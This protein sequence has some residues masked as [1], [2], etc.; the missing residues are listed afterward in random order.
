MGASFL[1]T[2]KV[3]STDRNHLTRIPRPASASNI[4]KG[5]LLGSP[6][7]RLKGKLDEENFGHF[8]TQEQSRTSFPLSIQGVVAGWYPKELEKTSLMS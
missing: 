1:H 7:Q 3:M 4:G 5:N 8:R 6:T 2:A